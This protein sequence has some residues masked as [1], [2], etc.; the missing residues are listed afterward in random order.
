MAAALVAPSFQADADLATALTTRAQRQ[1]AAVRPLCVYRVF[2]VCAPYLCLLAYFNC[3]YIACALQHTFIVFVIIILTSRLACFQVRSLTVCQ[4]RQALLDLCETEMLRLKQERQDVYQRRRAA[5]PR[6]Q[7][8]LAQLLLLQQ[9][10]MVH[11]TVQ[12]ANVRFARLLWWLCV[13]F[14][15][16]VGQGRVVLAV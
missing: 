3:V 4:R 13:C 1:F 14:Q 6:A 10:R 12:S 15:I 9:Q 16:C 5:L 8:A 7:A 11:A 2:V